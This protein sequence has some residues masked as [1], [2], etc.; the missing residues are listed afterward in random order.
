[1]FD[2]ATRSKPLS[3][4][5]HSVWG[6]EPT[7]C[8]TRPTRRR[9]L[10]VVQIYK[11]Y[12][13]V[14]GGIEN[15][16]KILASGL[17]ERGHDVTV[18]VT[19]IG[20]ATVRERRDG[21]EVIKAGRLLAVASTPIS[22]G[23]L[24]EARSLKA[25]VVNLHMPY[26][27]GDLAAR[28]V[29][30]APPLVATYHSDIVRQQRL[31]KLYR[32][33]LQA[34]LRRASR[35]IATSGPYIESSPFLRPL[36]TK[37]RVVPLS[38]DAARFASAA[39]RQVAALRRRWARSADDCVVLSVGVLRYYK[40][41]HFLLDAMAQIDATLVVVGQG[42]EERRL[43]DL[44]QAF[45]IARRVHFVG[46]VPDEQLSAYY[47][48]AD[49]FVLPSHLRSEAFGV[50]QLEAMAAGLPV[51]STALGTGTSVVNQHGTTGFV[52]PPSDGQAI[53]RS[54]EVLLANPELRRSLGDN[55][56]RRVEQEYTHQ[57][58][59]E[60]TEAVYREA[61]GTA[62]RSA[63]AGVK[64]GQDATGLRRA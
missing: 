55:G 39:P 8:Y 11:D 38:V 24:R 21:V 10:H 59:V 23:L 3:T 1:V 16:V 41:L 48:A 52:V 5:R 62:R 25:D 44:A 33:L 29:G 60:R 22:V 53:A 4:T 6:N 56:R 51:I 7:V 32:P 26:P 46:H 9:G 14:V 43:K 40:G 30:G 61:I 45:G 2:C 27:P 15:H 37:C 36:E 47:H 28:A 54:I 20:R 13:P 19:N 34:T 18:L 12:D 49:L 64:E 17:A 31:L 42:P 57:R 63:P 50:V 58:M 35:I